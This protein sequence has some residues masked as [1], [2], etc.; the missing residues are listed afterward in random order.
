MR[1]HLLS[2][3]Q[4]DKGS[5]VADVVVRF[6]NELLLVDLGQLKKLEDVPHS[7]VRIVNT[8]PD[9]GKV[10]IVVSIDICQTKTSP[11]TVMMSVSFSWIDPLEYSSP[12]SIVTPVHEHKLMNEK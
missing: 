1:D 12:S 3:L 4:P 6:S 2:V 9:V 5:P 7:M 10:R 11:K 8:L